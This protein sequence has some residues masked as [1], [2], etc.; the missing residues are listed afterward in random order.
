MGKKPKAVSKPKQLWKLYDVSSG[1]VTRK[2]S[3]CKRCG[4]G[5]FL[6]AHKDR[7][8]CGKCSYMERANAAPE[9]KPE[10]KPDVQKPKESKA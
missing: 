6:S 10:V 8:F 7:T 3:F 1:S 9:V 5:F 2:N 4:P